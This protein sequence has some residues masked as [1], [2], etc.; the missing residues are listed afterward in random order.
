[1]NNETTTNNVSTDTENSFNDCF[2]S[3]LHLE[4]SPMLFLSVI[5]TRNAPLMNFVD[6]RRHKRI[7][8]RNQKLNVPTKEGV[9]LRLDE[10]TQ[11]KDLFPKMIESSESEFTIIGHKER[12][13][14][15]KRELNGN[16]KLLLQ[17]GAQEKSITLD[18]EEVEKI[19]SPH[20]AER[21]HF[22]LKHIG[23]EEGEDVCGLNWGQ[24][25]KN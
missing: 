20:A 16:W 9:F 6:I 25:Q 7:K 14:Y 17:N 1:M 12:K 23:D 10:Y 18:Q 24:G 21:V 3:H 22:A 5:R 15:V 13:L 4:I 2:E 11:L 19:G 8:Q